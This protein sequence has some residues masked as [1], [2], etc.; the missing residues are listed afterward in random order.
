MSDDLDLATGVI[1]PDAVL[2][3]RYRLRSRLGHGG[4]A[5]VWL[6]F[7]ERLERPVAIKILSD[8]LAGDGVYLQRFRRE[9]RVAA[10]LQHPNLVPI[11]DFSA[12]SRPYLVMEYVDGGD[13]SVRLRADSAPDPEALAEQLLRR[14]AP[15]P[16]GR[17]DPP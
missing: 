5:V 15:Y 16:R 10:G 2:G 11:Y 4:M 7:D 12:G 17:R 3:G 14:F 1:A 8:T 6:A 9:A 13:L